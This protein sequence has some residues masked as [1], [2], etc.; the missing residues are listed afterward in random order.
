MSRAI[1]AASFVMFA[2]GGHALAQE[3]RGEG[4]DPM[5]MELPGGYRLTPLEPSERIDLGGGAPLTLERVLASAAQHHPSLEAARQDVRAAQGERLAAESAFDLGLTARAWGSPHGY[6]DWGRADVMLEQ[7]TP[8]WGLSLYTGWRIGR[9]DI[10]DYYGEHATLDLGEVRTGIRIPLWQDGPID[11]RRARLWRAE[12]GVDVERADLDARAL[13]TRLEA[14]SAYWSWVGAGLRYRVASDLLDLAEARDRQILA[15]V[16]AGA[17]P[18]IEALENRRVIVERRGS[19]VSARRSLERA[20]IALSLYYR[21]DDGRPLLV[22][23]DQ[24]PDA[25]TRRDDLSIDLRRA[26]A[27]A[28]D[29]RPELDRFHAM[30]AGQR[31][32]MELAENRLAPR[33]DVTLETSLDVGAG[34]PAENMVLGTPVV[35]GSVLISFPLQ[36]SE[37]RGGI[38]RTRAELASTR[39]DFQLARERVAAEV[40]D[41]YSALRAAIERLRLARESADVATAVAEAE[42]R[43]FELGATELFIVNLRE[44]AAAAARAELADADAAL[45][46]AY[47]QWDVVIGLP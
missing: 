23:P 37:A 26:I 11:A 5:T 22:S 21:D 27:D 29:R 44:Q 10:P 32:T 15:R 30:I 8:L 41:A 14:A 7:P 47:A 6:Y 2:L 40:A 17:I 46:V 13:R 43:R 12:P 34:T 39:A 20:A 19:L 33:I 42:R 16:R 18:P 31:V 3:P 4:L 45:Q 38:E 35:E 28:L 24:L 1:L 25:I 36:F 9:G